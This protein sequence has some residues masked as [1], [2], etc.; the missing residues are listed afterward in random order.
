M[1]KSTEKYAHLKSTRKVIGQLNQGAQV[2]NKLNFVVVIS[3]ILLIIF[4]GVYIYKSYGTADSGSSGT[5]KSDNV[6]NDVDSTADESVESQSEEEVEI[7]VQE[8]SGE[9]DTKPHQG[10]L[11]LVKESSGEYS[12]FITNDSVNTY[13]DAK[14]DE[15][16][17]SDYYGMIGQGKYSS[18]L[19]TD[20]RDFK[21]SIRLTKMPSKYD[22][23]EYFTFVDHFITGDNSTSYI[24]FIYEVE[25]DTSED[26]K[27][28]KYNVVA[29]IDLK[30]KKYSDI[31]SRELGDDSYGDII[32]AVDFRDVI[33][34]HIEAN[35]LS[36]FSCAADS[37]SEVI[38]INQNNSKDVLIGSA[39]KIVF[40]L[41]NNKIG[42][43]I[44]GERKE[45]DLP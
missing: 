25:D 36:C 11:Y 30:S 19:E 5:Q 35:L 27:F 14:Q 2:G 16:M 20:F 24:S 23:N 42:Y 32:G 44:D 43:E 13:Y 39:T 40:D 34:D 15:D 12:L 1:A 7:G 17:Q 45:S 33:G 8:I 37:P 18:S 3:I 29:K 22:V 38:I 41:G 9:I 28:I 21:E 26:E 31:W 10:V 4:G 6:Q